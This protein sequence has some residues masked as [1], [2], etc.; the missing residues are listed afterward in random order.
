MASADAEVDTPDDEKATL[1]SF[2]CGELPR[3][4]PAIPVS[5]PSVPCAPKAATDARGAGWSGVR[6]CF[7]RR[8]GSAP[9]VCG[10]HL[11][12]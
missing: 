6:D 4:S 5:R 11:L 1:C 2:V 7:L 12:L 10:K 9:I 3:W 8:A